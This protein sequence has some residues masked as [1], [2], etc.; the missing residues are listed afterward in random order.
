MKDKYNGMT[1]NRLSKILL[2][3]IN[4]GHGRRKVCIDKETFKHPL[5]PDGCIILDVEGVDMSWVNNLDDEGYLK[6]N[7][8]GSQS[9]RMTCLLNGG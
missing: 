4:D 7:K 9:G 6:E 1:V 2:Q 5:E 3:A 8:D